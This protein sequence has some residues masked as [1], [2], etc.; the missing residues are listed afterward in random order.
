M[1]IIQC[2]AKGLEVFCGAYLSQDK[3][4]MQELKDGLDIHGINQREILNLGSHE[5]GRL[6]A[7]IFVFRLMY[8]GS[9]YSYAHDPDFMGVSTSEKHW[10]KIIDNFYEKY[11]GFRDWHTH[12][13]REATSKGYLIMPTGRRY[14]FSLKRNF[15]GE[16][17]APQTI[18][19]NYP[20]Q[21]LG[22]DVMAIARV[23][24]AKRF[25]KEEIQGE[26]IGTVHDSIVCDIPSVEV[27]RVAQLFHGV[28]DDLPNNFYKVFGVEFNLPLK[29]EVKYG[30]NMLEMKEFKLTT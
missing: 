1:P 10:Q 30:P 2:D 3:V 14:N 11:K 7:K 13:L 18:I 12:I 19:K 6:I 21:G 23:S 27:P 16:L 17:E 22:A 8:G 20:V 25:R 9:A 15:R 24:F 26:C 28:F 5:D 4:L 29:C